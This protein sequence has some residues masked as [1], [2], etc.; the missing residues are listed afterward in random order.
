MSGGYVVAIGPSNGGNGVLD[1]DGTFIINGGYL[2][3]CGCSGMNQKPTLSSG[4]CGSTAK[5]SISNKYLTLNVSSTTVLEIYVSKSNINYIVYAGYGSDVS[6]SINSNA[7]IGDGK[8]GVN[9]WEFLRLKEL[10][11]SI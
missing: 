2:L 8:Y 5:A 1:F 9:K 10:K 6:Y 11:K 4:V 3:A 7:S